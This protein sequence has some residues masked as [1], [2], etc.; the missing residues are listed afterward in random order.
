M[1]FGVI[2]THTQLRVTDAPKNN[3]MVCGRDGGKTSINFLTARAEYV[4]CKSG[5]DDFGDSPQK[6]EKSE[7]CGV[8]RVASVFASLF[9]GLCV[10]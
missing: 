8:K 10:F 7:K 6:S 1:I 4:R 3:A 9:V 5:D 2:D